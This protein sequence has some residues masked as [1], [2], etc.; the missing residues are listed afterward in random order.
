MKKADLKCSREFTAS[1][2]SSENQNWEKIT[3]KHNAQDLEV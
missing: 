2:K 3:E 1:K